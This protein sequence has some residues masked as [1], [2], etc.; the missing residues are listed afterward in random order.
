MASDYGTNL[1]GAM[2]GGTAE[3]LSLVTGFGPLLGIVAL[4]YAGAVAARIV[5]GRRVSG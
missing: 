2:A 4:F 3:Y 5:S 1:L